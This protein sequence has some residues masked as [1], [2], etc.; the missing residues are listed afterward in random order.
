V[1]VVPARVARRWRFAVL[2]SFAWA[3]AAPAA[4]AD[5]ATVKWNPDWPRFRPSEWALTAGLGLNAAQALF[6]YPSP[7][8]NWEGGILFDDAV[9]DAIL[10]KNRDDRSIAATWSDNLYYLLG[11]YPMVVDTA[12]V[13]AGIHGAGDVAFQMMMMNFES[14]AL[15]G[16]VALTA[17]KLGRVR[18][19]GADCAR[20]PNYD[21]TCQ[22]GANLNA[23]LLSG[24]TTVAFAGAALMCAHHANLPLYGSKLADGAACATGLVAATA[25]GVLR[26]MS[27]NHYASDVLLGSGVGVF[28]GY[29]WPSLWHYGFGGK[30]G[31]AGSA[32]FLPQ[33][34]ARY[35]EVRLSGVLYPN[36]A[37]T[38]IGLTMAL[39]LGV[40]PR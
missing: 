39:D 12:I 30:G 34:H 36:I 24:H 9:R 3:I 22:T 1:R 20:D 32:S 11:V 16:A 28:A 6:L 33:V 13:T 14:Y 29:V 2:V 31:V 37:P 17:E 38:M 35:G 5:S 40:A 27:D 15:A 19:M 26:I 10:L 25:A 8:A 18:P 7:K 4:R 21:G 23:S